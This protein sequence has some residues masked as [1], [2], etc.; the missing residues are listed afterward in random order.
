MARCN[1]CIHKEIC[2]F[3]N[4]LG[5]K[6]LCQECGFFINQ[7][8][9]VPKSEVEKIFEEIDSIFQKQFEK[10]SEN[11]ELKL[12]EPLLQA[13]RFVINEMW[14]EVAELKKKYTESEDTK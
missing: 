7:A 13:E 10:C 6:A 8:D 1:E 9:V 3:Y 11:T 2:Q 14:H 5:C 12:L 4:A